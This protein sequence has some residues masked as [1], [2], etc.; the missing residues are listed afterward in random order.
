MSQ[1]ATGTEGDKDDTEVRNLLIQL[2]ERPSNV[3]AIMGDG[4]VAL[5]LDVMGLAQCSQAMCRILR[6]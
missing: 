5:I 3:G 6:C 1:S 2:N 4:K